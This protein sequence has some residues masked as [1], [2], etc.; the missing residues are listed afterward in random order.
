MNKKKAS[1]TPITLEEQFDFSQLN[2]GTEKMER[3][4][5][6]FKCIACIVISI[7]FCEHEKDTPFT[8]EILEFFELDG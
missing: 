5:S 7:K 3:Y 4:D 1:F 6:F 8:K 2:N